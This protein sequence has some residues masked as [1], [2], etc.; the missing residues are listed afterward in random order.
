MAVVALAAEVARV[1]IIHAMAGVAVLRCVLVL[2][3]GMAKGTPHAGVLAHEW[4]PGLS[5]VEFGLL[6]PSLLVVTILAFVSE[7]VVV[8]IV[9]TM[10][11]N[12]EGIGFSI[13]SLV[14][15]TSRTGRHL[16]STKER[17][18]REI[19]REGVRI[20]TGDIRISADVLRVTDA[21]FQ[22]LSLVPAVKSVLLLDVDRHF[23]V[24][25]EAQR[26][27]LCSLKRAVTVAALPLDVRV[28]LD[29]LSGHDDLLDLNAQSREWQDKAGQHAD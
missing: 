11:L 28:T 16:V 12:A 26:A 27:L 19:V 8:W 14:G 10:A 9:I 25:I 29:H 15:M 3:V 17:E 21:A 5:M 13:E 4:K 18:V 6:P 20:E 1:S 2:V 7:R 22:L 23:V 24:A